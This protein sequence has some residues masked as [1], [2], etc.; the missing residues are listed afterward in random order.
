MVAGNKPGICE[1][2]KYLELIIIGINVPIWSMIVILLKKALNHKKDTEQSIRKLHDLYFSI[3]KH[4]A[5]I[6]VEIKHIRDNLAAKT[7]K[8]IDDLDALHSKVRELERH[9]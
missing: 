5:V 8:A 2:M 9:L 6:D 3:E 1:K 4:L 7:L